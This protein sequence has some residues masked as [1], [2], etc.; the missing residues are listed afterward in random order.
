MNDL[1]TLRI[2]RPE[3]EVAMTELRI[4]VNIL[5]RGHGTL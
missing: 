5:N 2:N 1:D 3:P 4:P